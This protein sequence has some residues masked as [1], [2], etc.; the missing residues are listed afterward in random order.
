[1]NSSVPLK[2]LLPRILIL[3]LNTDKALIDLILKTDKALIDFSKQ[4]HQFF[5]ALQEIS[6]I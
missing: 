5:G 2:D 1:M 4:S 6:G 3:I